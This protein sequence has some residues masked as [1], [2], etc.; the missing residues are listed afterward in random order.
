MSAESR[1]VTSPTG[2]NRPVPSMLSSTCAASLSNDCGAA[3]GWLFV[4]YCSCRPPLNIDDAFAG[5]F[6]AVSIS[7]VGTMGRLP[8]IMRASRK[9]RRPTVFGAERPVPKRSAGSAEIAWR[10]R[11]STAARLTLENSLSSRSGA[12]TRVSLVMLTASVTLTPFNCDPFC[13]YH[14]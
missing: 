10:I 9:A 8:V 1:C 7:L 2:T 11:P 12:T 4:K 13:P 3:A 14:G 6:V 5:R